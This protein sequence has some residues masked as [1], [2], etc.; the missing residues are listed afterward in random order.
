MNDLMLGLGKG[1][2]PSLREDGVRRPFNMPKA[3][4]RSLFIAYT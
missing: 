4:G 3:L 2:D 1:L